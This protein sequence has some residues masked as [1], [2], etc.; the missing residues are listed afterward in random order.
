M[1]RDA[2]TLIQTASTVICVERLPQASS[3][4]M[5]MMLDIALFFTN[6]SQNRRLGKHKKP[7]KDVRLKRLEMTDRSSRHSIEDGLVPPRCYD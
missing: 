1:R 2:G 4:E 7:A 3:D 5:M 6:R